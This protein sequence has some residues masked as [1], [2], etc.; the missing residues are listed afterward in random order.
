MTN[1]VS[2]PYHRFY[3]N[4]CI[5]CFEKGNYSWCYLSDNQKKYLINSN[6]L[7][8]ATRVDIKINNGQRYELTVDQFKSWISNGILKEECHVGLGGQMEEICPECGKK[9]II[10]TARKGKN[11]GNQFYGCSG[12]PMCR[13]IK[14]IKID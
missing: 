2:Y 13:Y 5:I 7:D 8:G 3:N 6:Y 9:L 10:R 14:D 4:T 1:Y 12:F 11:A